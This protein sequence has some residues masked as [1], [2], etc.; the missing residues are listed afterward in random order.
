MLPYRCIH[1]TAIATAIGQWLQADFLRI[2]IILP[3]GPLENLAQ[4]LPGGQR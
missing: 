3:R 4:S 1:L 2:Q